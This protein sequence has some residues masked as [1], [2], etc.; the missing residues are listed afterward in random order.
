MRAQNRHPLRDHATQLDAPTRRAF[1]SQAAKTFLGVGALPLVSRTAFAESSSDQSPARGSAQRVIYL[2]M[3]GGMSHLDTFDTKPG[4]DTQGPVDSI[5]TNV[6]GLKI[7]EYFP[8]MAQQMDKV[9][10]INSMNS[11]QGAHA[12]GRYFMHTSYFMRGTIKHPDLGAYTSLLMPESSSMLPSNVKIGGNSSGLGAGFLES[13]YAAVPIGDPDAGLQ[14]SQLP[15]RITESRFERR[16]SRVKEMNRQFGKRYSTKSVRAYAGMYDDA[17]SLMKSEDLQAF[18]LTKESA[19]TRQRYGE[20][21]FGQGV[22]LAR[23]LVEHDV[24][25]VE[26]DYGG[27]DTHTDNFTRV[28]EKSATLDQA[29][30]ALL[31]DL[32]VRGLLE[33]TLVVLATEFGRTPQIVADRNNGRNHYPKA[34]TCLLA[35]GGIQGGQRWG[36][37]DEEGREVVDDQVSVPDFNATIAYALGLPLK[38]KI[39]SPSK[40]PFTVADE[41]EPLTRLFG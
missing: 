38:E 6:S 17:V 30:A 36:R 26:V 22:L 8:S 21:K 34:F 12:Q 29:L 11:T 27:W 1:V 16:L 23:R 4:T 20:D 31:E 13:K 9:A 35:G 24:R 2:Y 19:A 10:V 33:E 32:A 25:F 15:N 3:S 18:D 37:T 5:A 28:E 39:Y 40:R 14:H 41:G 7:S